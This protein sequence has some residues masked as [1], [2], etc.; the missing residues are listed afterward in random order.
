MRRQDESIQIRCSFCDKEQD[1]VDKLIAGPKGY[2]CNECI[3][4]C[5]GMIQQEFGNDNGKSGE[6]LPLK[7]PL[8]K[9]KWIK[10]SLDKYVVGQ[11]HAKKILSVGV[12]NHFKRLNYSWHPGEDSVE[13]QKS[14]IL[15][16]GPSG[17]G[18]T[19]LVSSL[20]MIIKVPFTIVDAT[21]LTEAGYVGED[22]ESILFR[23]YQAAKQNVRNAERGIIYVDEIDKISKKT[24]GPS[25][26]RD[27]SGEGVQQGLLR[28]MEGAKVTIP[29]P[30][31]RKLFREQPVS[32]NTKN[33]LFICGGAFSGLEKIIDARTNRISVGF[34]TDSQSRRER[35]VGEILKSAEPLD[36]FNFGM[37]PEFIGRVPIIAPLSDL[38]ED[39]LI[40]V[41]QEPK[42]ALIKQ[43]KALFSL[44]D[45][46]LN[47]TQE[48]IKA[49]A[50][51]ALELDTG[52]RGLRAIIE[53]LMLEIMFEIPSNK[54]IKKFTVT[55][56]FISNP[57]QPILT[58]QSTG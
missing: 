13:L 19:L 9:P 32:I 33:I 2:I 49:I 26:S 41:L 36:L 31:T 51:K 28:M 35:N 3:R 17:C 29:M 27:V 55:K 16:L 30:R 1:R 37:I 12:Y 7:K 38:N 5:T 53:E 44:E 14:N 15:L 8:L 4:K 57:K 45:I 39:D 18:K 48:A 56:E 20:A 11:E 43:Y 58:Y 21:T 40:K 54:D 6:A 47:F 52:A 25:V 24:A 10:S 23:L 46:E 42:N 50:G 22:V 34:S